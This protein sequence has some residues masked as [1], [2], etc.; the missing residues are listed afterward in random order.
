MARHAL[1]VTAF[2]FGLS[3]C[4]SSIVVALPSI[5]MERPVA[6]LAVGGCCKVSSASAV[7]LAARTSLAKS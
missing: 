6:A 1:D 5:R 4:D 7:S 3:F 2:P